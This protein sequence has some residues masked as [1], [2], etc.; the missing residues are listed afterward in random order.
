MELFPNSIHISDGKIR[1][2]YLCASSVCLNTGR[3]TGTLFEKARQKHWSCL[4]HYLS[5]LQDRIFSNYIPIRW[6]ETFRI[7]AYIPNPERPLL[8]GIT[9]DARTRSK[10][11]QHRRL[12]SGQSRKPLL[13]GPINDALPFPSPYHGSMASSTARVGTY[14]T[15]DDTPLPRARIELGTRPVRHRQVF[16]PYRRVSTHIRYRSRWDGDS[17]V[18]SEATPSIVELSPSY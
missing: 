7:L 5:Q 2:G 1:F 10:W 14:E 12:K 17:D 16:D 3:K 11:V 13:N 15:D 18:T 4:D 6:D 8:L 9:L